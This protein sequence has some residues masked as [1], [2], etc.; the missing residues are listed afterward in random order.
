MLCLSGMLL[1]TSAFGQM[2]FVKGYIVTLKGDTMKGEIRQNPKKDVDNFTKVYFRVSER[3]EGK[4]YHAEKLQGYG[5]LTQTFIQKKV[6]GEMVFVRVEALGA[7][8]L[9]ES[10]YETEAMNKIVTDSDFYVEK[11]GDEKANLIHIKSGKFKKD[12][13]ELLKDDTDLVQDIDQQKYSFDDIQ[14]VIN[15]YNQWAK[16]QNH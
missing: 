1:N 3:E 8:N 7:L 5:F 10:K 13:A 14:D 9:Y 12:M 2:T 15:Q 16:Q 11:N 4:T 6:D